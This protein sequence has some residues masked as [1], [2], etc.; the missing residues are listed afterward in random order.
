MKKELGL[1]E[2]PTKIELEKII[3]RDV[4]KKLKLKFKEKTV[5]FSEFIKKRPYESA[6]LL[7]SNIKYCVVKCWL[8]ITELSYCYL[9]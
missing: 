3:Y 2:D 9:T 6:D 7:D 8:L 5:L 1:I 4:K